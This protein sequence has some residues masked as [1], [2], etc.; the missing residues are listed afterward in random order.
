[1]FRN[2][3]EVHD[4]PC[5]I[6]VLSPSN[7][8]SAMCIYIPKDVSTKLTIIAVVYG[9]DRVFWGFMGHESKGNDLTWG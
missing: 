7:Y 6:L 5:Q 9:S 8:R 3:L 1:M 4:A 2:Y